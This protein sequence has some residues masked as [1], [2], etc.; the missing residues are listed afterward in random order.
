MKLSRN[1]PAVLGFL[2]LAAA[3]LSCET[4]T[5]VLWV[6]VDC[7]DFTIS[8][9]D[10][11]EL[12]FRPAGSTQIRG[13]SNGTWAGGDIRY[14]TETRE[15]VNLFVVTASGNWIRDQVMANAEKYPG[16]F[17][18]ELP[19]KNV[20]SAGTFELR[21][22]WRYHG[23]TTG[24]ARHPTGGLLTLPDEDGLFS[25]TIFRLTNDLCLANPSDS[26]TDAEVVEAVDPSEDW[27][28]D[29]VEPSEE[30]EP[31]GEDDDAPE[32]DGPD[33]PDHIDDE[34]GEEAM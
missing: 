7:T 1:I 5:K 3:A 14:S 9:V 30:V 21:G 25:I 24:E 20:G 23:V 17:L 33:T 12:T 13:N 2:V 15:G 31:S 28:E 8:C 16:Q 11:F 10:D 29:S 27:V 19:M 4:S 32:R 18:F 22:S 6:R 34:A 26:E